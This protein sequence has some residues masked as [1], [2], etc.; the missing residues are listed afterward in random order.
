MCDA[1]GMAPRRYEQ[2][3]RAVNAE[4]TRRRILDAVD[5]RL[6]EAPTEPLSLDQV[7]RVARVAR[8]TIYTAFGSRSGLLDAF[9]E[10]LWARSGL[11]AL[12]EAVAHTD[13]REH[14]R[15]GF[16]AA[17]RMF[18]AERDVYRVLFSMA[19]LD[20]ASVGGAVDRMVRE[21]A[22]GMAHLAQ[23]LADEGV[24]AADTSVE[25]AAHILWVLTSFESFDLL[26]T[27]RGLPLERV[28]DLLVRTAERAVCRPR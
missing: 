14:L 16:A 19:Q 10:D 25:D 6:R 4:E 26:F 5:Q 20:P 15:G 11:P 17:S 1:A 3:L 28:V 13:V 22:G 27:T 7:A 18:A 9:A 21:R 2:T 8:S 12:T 24:L 23:R